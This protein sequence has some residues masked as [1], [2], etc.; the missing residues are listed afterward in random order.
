VTAPVD[1]FILPI[2][3][4]PREVNQ[5]LP[6]G[7]AAM[8]AIP[9]IDAGTLKN[10]TLPF[11]TLTLPIRGTLDDRS[12]SQT[13]P[14]ESLVMASGMPSNP[15]ANSVNPRLLRRLTSSPP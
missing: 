11:S 1:G 15:D 4:V 5:M 8:P 7:P 12:L 10:D 6:S 9:F 2:C 14:L 3:A 13:L